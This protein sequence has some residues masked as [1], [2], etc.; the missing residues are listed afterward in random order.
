MYS[1]YYTNCIATDLTVTNCRA[2]RVSSVSVVRSSSL[3]F[4]V[5]AHEGFSFSQYQAYELRNSCVVSS[6]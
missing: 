6:F 1:K 5:L 4:Q 3:S 2:E